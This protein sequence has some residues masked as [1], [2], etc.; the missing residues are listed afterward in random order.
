M[1]V[2]LVQ[3]IVRRLAALDAE[4]MQEPLQE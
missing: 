3:Q 1:Q 2:T 4:S